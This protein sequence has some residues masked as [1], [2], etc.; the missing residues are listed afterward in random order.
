MR[1]WQRT[2]VSHRL[3][4]AAQNGHQEGQMSLFGAMSTAISGLDAQSAAFA[5]I[6]DNTAN[7]QTVGFK[8]TDTSFVDYLSSSSATENQSGSVVAIDGQGFFQ[9]S[10]EQGANSTGTPNFNTQ[11]YYTRTGDFS[12][13]SQGYLVNSAGEYLNGWTVDQST[14]IL[15]TSATAPIQVQQTQFQPVATANVSLLANVPTTPSATSTLS[16]EVQIYDATGTAH[17]LTT[18]WNPVSGTPNDWTLTLSSPDN[19]GGSTIGSVNVQFGSNGTL[20]SLTNASLNVAVNGSGSGAGNTA[21]VTL[22]PTFN[23][24]SQNINLNLGVFDSPTGVTQ[25]AGTNYDLQSITQDGAAPGSFTGISDDN[26]GAIYANFNNGRSVQIAEVPI[27][28]FE[29]PDALQRQNGQS[30]TTTTDSGVAI[31][32]T[33]NQNGAGSLVTGSVEASNVDIAT[34]LSNLIVAQQAYGANAKVI[35]TANQMLQTTLDIK[36]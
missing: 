32:Q 7:S 14:G 34:Q 24:N 15:N 5:N 23:N 26:T 1:L 13:D 22:T 12:L 36:Q 30:F 2:A 35:A 6:S 8:G 28:T 16:S 21:S 10:E 17:Q 18:T 31:S 9:V 33:Q 20:E 4:E 29:N 11:P 3:T 27:I 19:T 25:F